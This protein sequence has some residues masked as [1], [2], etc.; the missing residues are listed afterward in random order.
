MQCCQIDKWVVGRSISSVTSARTWSGTCRVAAFLA[1]VVFSALVLVAVF[2]ELVTAAAGV[3]VLVLSLIV[4]LPPPLLYISDIG[5][6]PTF[7]TEIVNSSYEITRDAIDIP[8]KTE[9]PLTRWGTGNDT[10]RGPWV[11]FIQSH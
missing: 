4:K 6:G 10:G 3:V 7:Y 8:A 5:P 11:F 1:I 2:E 9:K